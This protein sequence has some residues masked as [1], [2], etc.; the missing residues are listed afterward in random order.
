MSPLLATLSLMNGWVEGYFQG[1]I[2]VS[3]FLVFIDFWMCSFLV[4]SGVVG[5][6]PGYA[7]CRL[8]GFCVI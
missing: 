2:F 7:P 6:T 5:W 1:A 4:Y 3:V 8:H